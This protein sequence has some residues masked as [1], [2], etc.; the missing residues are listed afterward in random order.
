MLN[1]SLL[2]I[3]S[4]VLYRRRLFVEIVCT[5]FVLVLD[6]II[7]VSIVQVLVGMYVF[8]VGKDLFFLVGGR[9]CF[10]YRGG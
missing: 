8:Q 1:I 10:R 2:R 6:L 9:N 3:F 7:P 4:V 5:F